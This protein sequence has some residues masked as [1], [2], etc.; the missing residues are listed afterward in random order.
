MSALIGL[1]TSRYKT[2]WKCWMLTLDKLDSCSR[3]RGTRTALLGYGSSQSKVWIMIISFLDAPAPLYL[4]VG[5]REWFM[6]NRSEWTITTWL[7]WKPWL[8]VYRD[9][10]AALAVLVMFLIEMFWQQ[11]YWQK[12]IFV[13]TSQLQDNVLRICL[14]A[15]MTAFSFSTCLNSSTTWKSHH[16]AQEAQQE[17]ELV[18]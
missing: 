16:S 14:D 7:I 8:R 17:V 15:T 1:G 18:I 2:L 4:G 6:I 9:W 13:D 10:R 12:K 5:V 11:T 3:S